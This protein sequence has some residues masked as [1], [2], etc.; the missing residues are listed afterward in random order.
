MSDRPTR[1]HQPRAPSRATRLRPAAVVAHFAWEQTPPRARPAAGR[2]LTVPAAG[3]CGAPAGRRVA[4]RVQ[5][6]ARRP[7]PQPRPLHL[8]VHMRARPPALGPSR[9]DLMTPGPAACAAAACTAG[10]FRGRQAA[11]L[12]LAARHSPDAGQ[13]ACASWRHAFALPLVGAQ[14]ER[15][16]HRRHPPCMPACVRTRTSTSPRVALRAAAARRAPYAWTTAA[17]PKAPLPRPGAHCCCGCLLLGPSSPAPTRR[18]PGN[19]RVPARP[20][21]PARRPT[22]HRTAQRAPGECRV[23]HHLPTAMPCLLPLTATTM[24]PATLPGRRPV[25][26]NG[27][28]G[29]SQRWRTLRSATSAPPWSQLARFSPPH[30]GLPLPT[31]WRPSAQ[32]GRM[33]APWLPGRAKP[34]PPHSI[35]ARPLASACSRRGAEPRFW[36]RTGPSPVCVI[37][38]TQASQCPRAPHAYALAHL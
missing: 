38:I 9:C 7:H 3:R 32:G 28:P 27:R 37:A 21:P 31:A 14:L 23:T 1:G 6:H 8:H 19:R 33:P 20:A 4:A 10:F 36:G 34:T 12:L 30:L 13:G 5:R 24:P 15:G 26:H 29:G 35:T 2:P 22:F 25:K 16:C 11:P 17:R 18:H